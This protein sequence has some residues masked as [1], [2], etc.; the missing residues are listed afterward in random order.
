MLSHF[1]TILEREG[2]TDGRTDR[3]SISISHVS[4]AV[5][6]RDKNYKLRAKLPE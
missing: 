2:Q 5:L 6:T 3:I 1:D 4:L